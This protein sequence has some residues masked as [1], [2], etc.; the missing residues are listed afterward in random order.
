MELSV[1][2][3]RISVLRQVSEGSL[4]AAAGA[5]RS[6]WGV[7]RRHFR[8]LR[9]RFE[10]E[11]DAA[12]V[13]GLHGRPSNRSLPVG[14][15]ERAMGG[16]GGSVVPGLRADAAGRASGAALRRG[17]ERRDATAL[18]ARGRVVAAAAAAPQASRAAPCIH[19]AR[20]GPGTWTEREQAAM[21]ASRASP[22][23]TST[24]RSK[25]STSR[26]RE[27]STDPSSC[28]SFPGRWIRDGQT[29][30]VS[31]ATGSGKSYLACVLGHQAC[32]LGI[33][34]RYY[35][36]S[37]L[38]DDGGLASL[39]GQGRHNLLKHTHCP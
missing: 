27:A 23:S 16:R 5:E 26:P 22:S 2:W 18:D 37:R 17:R 21:C 7:T 6:G 29:V 9:R 30:L 25:T 28:A 15:R 4:T 20:P 35:R 31:G 1:K 13:H 11:G 12:V 38:L 14:I 10:A 19:S 39:S 33:S 24:P 36:V 32:R 8:R 3:D 34:T